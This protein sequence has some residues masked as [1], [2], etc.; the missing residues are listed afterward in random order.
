M[1]VLLGCLDFAKGS[2]ELHP[3][4]LQETV[5]SMQFQMNAAGLQHMSSACAC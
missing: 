2:E 3:D 5:C 4:L 1:M